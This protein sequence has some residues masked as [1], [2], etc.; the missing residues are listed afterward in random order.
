METSGG[1][2]GVFT[3]RLPSDA[4]TFPARVITTGLLNQIGSAFRQSGTV[5][6][7]RSLASPGFELPMEPQ[8]PLAYQ[9]VEATTDGWM[10]V[11][12]IESGLSGWLYANEA[13]RS[14]TLGRNLPELRFVD[15]AIGYLEFAKGADPAGGS[16]HLCADRFPPQETFPKGSSDCQVNALELSRDRPCPLPSPF[17]WARLHRTPWPSK[18]RTR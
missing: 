13:L 12:E 6:R 8:I 3:A 16:L 9:V 7:E 2:H 18:T 4:M 1:G 17:K 5:H 11:R 10:H 15:G 14:Q